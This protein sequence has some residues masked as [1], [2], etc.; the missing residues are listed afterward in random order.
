MPPSFRD[1]FFDI[2]TSGVYLVNFI[3]YLID[4]ATNQPMDYFLGF[5]HDGLLQNVLD[6]VGF[7]RLTI[8]FNCVVIFIIIFNLARKL[9]IVFPFLSV[10]SKTLAQ[11]SKHLFL[12]GHIIL[13]IICPFAVLGIN[14]FGQYTD[15][16]VQTWESFFNLILFAAGSANFQAL[17]DANP[18]AAVPFFIIL[19]VCF[20]LFM[21]ILFVAILQHS[22]WRLRL[23]YQKTLEAYD[24]LGSED[25][26]DIEEK[27]LN[28]FTC[29]SP[30]Q[31]AQAKNS[32]SS[33]TGFLSPNSLFSSG[34]VLMPNSAL[35][36]SSAINA[37]KF[38]DEIVEGIENTDGLENEKEPEVKPAGLTT[39]NI[40]KYN[41]RQFNIFGWSKRSKQKTK[42]NLVG[43]ILRKMG[44][45]E[46]ENAST[47]RDH[48]KYLQSTGFNRLVS[49]ICYIFFLI[50]FCIMM[51]LHL[52]NEVYADVRAGVVTG[53]ENLRTTHGNFARKLED[54]EQLPQL[55]EW[56]DEA[57]V[58]NLFET[59][60]NFGYLDYEI[61]Q[62]SY[63]SGNSSLA[64]FNVFGGEKNTFKSCF[65]RHGLYLTVKHFLSQLP[66]N[67]FLV[68]PPDFHSENVF[69]ACRS[70][71]H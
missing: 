69:L 56:I 57:Y 24:A 22:F 49:G 42:A 55:K 70:K 68:G 9:G 67:F 13:L 27:W 8:T 58:T 28:L 20:F 54:I 39:M 19:Y 47:I 35:V 34:R 52:E 26:G 62:T 10:V 5:Q 32:G 31:V 16:F 66:C 7:I 51:I 1:L 23:S 17:N 44:E 46:Q 48:L 63:L 30:Y 21:T 14:L 18:D 64:Y 29:K 15:E 60:Q 61:P 37:P 4:I 25:K 50:N 38:Q 59:P 65:R 12:Y 71:R 11:A 41:L 33:P 40:L 2:I 36:K 43:D 53:L 6:Y 3:L 45:Q